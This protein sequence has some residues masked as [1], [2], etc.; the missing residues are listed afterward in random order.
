[1]VQAVCTYIWGYSTSID[2]LWGS[3]TDTNSRKVLQRLGLSGGLTTSV[4][5]WRNFCGGA[6]ARA[7]GV[8][9]GLHPT[10]CHP[11][12]VGCKLRDSPWFPGSDRQAIPEPHH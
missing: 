10:G 3:Q 7:Q 6:E 8:S 9:H 2:G 11:H 1:M 5:N 4:T 12:P